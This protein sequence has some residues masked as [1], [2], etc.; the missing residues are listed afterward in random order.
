[1][2]YVLYVAQLASL[3][4]ALR[5]RV[6]AASGVG[7]FEREDDTNALVHFAAPNRFGIM[8]YLDYLRPENGNAYLQK[9][10]GKKGAAQAGKV[11]ALIPGSPK[12]GHDRA[13]R[14]ADRLCD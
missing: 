2:E 3:P 13:A 4:D 7:A 5:E 8:C 1:M 9:I 12:P 10:L 11:P 6:I 14:P